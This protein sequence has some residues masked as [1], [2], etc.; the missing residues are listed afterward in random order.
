MSVLS[1]SNVIHGIV[2]PAS[3]TG[4]FLEATRWESRWKRHLRQIADSA[5]REHAQGVRP[6]MAAALNAPLGR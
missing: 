1:H 6:A 4:G 2:I 3:E 5:V